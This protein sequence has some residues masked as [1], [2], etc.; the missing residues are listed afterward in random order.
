MEERVP[1]RE[2]DAMG[3][4]TQLSLPMA[5]HMSAAVVAARTS[6]CFSSLASPTAS[7]CE[8]DTTHGLCMHGFLRPS[9]PD[10]LLHASTALD[11]S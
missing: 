7:K 10:A 5:F 9:V 1:G 6:A 4:T 3:T 2:V 11:S 8:G